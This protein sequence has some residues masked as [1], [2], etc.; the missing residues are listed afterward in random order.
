[1]TSDP[2]ALIVLCTCPDQ[3]T[4][5][6][7][8]AAAV[9]A[10]LAACVNIVPGLLSVFKWQGVLER[11]AEVLLIAKTTSAAYPALEQLWRTQHPYEL[12][13]VIAVPITAGSEAYLQW[14][15]A[16]LTRS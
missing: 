9:T 1:M 15:N 16:A 12:P 2:A 6:Q 3:A 10:D 5:E 8:A 14:I 11:A 4:A 13:E 7:L